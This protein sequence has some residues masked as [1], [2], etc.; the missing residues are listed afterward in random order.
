MGYIDW[1]AVQHPWLAGPDMTLADLVAAA[2]LSVLDYFGD[3]DW[4][5]SQE[6][7]MYMKLKSR[8]VFS[9]FFDILGACLQ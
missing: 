2:H 4:D 5:R 9:H 8:P 1:L 3:V 6:A 7:K